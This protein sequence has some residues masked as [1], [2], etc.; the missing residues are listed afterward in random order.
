MKKFFWIFFIVLLLVSGGVFSFLYWGTYSEGIRAGQVIKLT[1]QGFIFKT[2]EGQLNLDTFGAIKG[3][4]AIRE[5]F[6]FSV[7]PSQIA[8]TAELETVALS[9][10][11]VS[12]HYK[13]RFVSWPWLGETKY[14]ITRVERIK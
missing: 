2:Y 9:G 11:R 3:A 6:E 10:E 7:E 14:F 13:E 1:K 8:L 4:T 12:L 5:T